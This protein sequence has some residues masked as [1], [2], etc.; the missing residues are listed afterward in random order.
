MRAWIGCILLASCLHPAPILGLNSS[1]AQDESASIKPSSD[2]LEAEIRKFE[3]ADAKR[4]PGPGGVVFVGSSSIRGWDIARSFADLGVPAIRR[5]FGGSQLS[6]SVYY[7]DRIVTKYRPRVVV[8]YAG[9]ND[10]AAGKSPGQVLADYKAFVAK[11]RA[12]QPGVRIVY[13]G[14]KPSIARWKLI[15]KIREA[16][17][18]ISEEIGKDPSL[19]FVDVEADMLG[20]DGRPRRELFGRDGLHMSPFG[21]QLWTAKVRPHLG[22][23]KQA[24][25]AS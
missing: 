22:P 7:A 8:L 23:A 4:M 14:I 6:D 17:R 10:L 24:P 1:H 25:D 11:V 16:N 13:I 19:V 20:L 21:Y 5:G 3:E 15:D 2:R 18:L 12:A 9:D